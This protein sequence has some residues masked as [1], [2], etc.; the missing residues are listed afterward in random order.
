MATKIIHES[1]KRKSAI[2]RATLKAGSGVVKINNISLSIYEPK[3]AKARIEEPMI[4][5]GDVAKKVDVSVNV[6]GGGVSSQADA[7]RLAI[8]KALAEHNPDLRQKFLDYDRQLI[9]ADVRFKESRKPNSH[10][11]ARAKRQKSYR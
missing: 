7:I 8:A 4:I 3:L 1:G 9:V 10:G 2:A 6:I 5:A 11:K